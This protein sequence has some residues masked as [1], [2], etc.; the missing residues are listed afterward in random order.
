MDY[1]SGWKRSGGTRRFPLTASPP[2]LY[3]GDQRDYAEMCWIRNDLD[4]ARRRF[5]HATLRGDFGEA[6]AAEQAWNAKAEEFRAMLGVVV[7]KPDG[8]P[9]TDEEIEAAL[10]AVRRWVDHNI[11]RGRGAHERL[12]PVGS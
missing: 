5:R 3:L 1:P 7:L 8:Q 6:V 12:A 10:M 2:L 11:E 4:S 9:F